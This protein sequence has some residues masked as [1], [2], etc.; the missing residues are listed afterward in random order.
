MH[1]HQQVRAHRRPLCQMTDWHLAL[2]LAAGQ[3]S[4]VV[5][6]KQGQVFVIKGIYKDRTS[7]VSSRANDDGEVTEVRTLT[8]CFI[9]AIRA[10]DFTPNSDTFGKAFIIR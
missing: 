2:A 5:T 6:S 9:P 3:V 4:G 7:K 8:D 10:L 1:F